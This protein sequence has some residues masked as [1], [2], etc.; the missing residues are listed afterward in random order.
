MIDP[1]QLAS[2][3][4]GNAISLALPGL[5]WA[6][7]FLL[8][9]ERGPFAASVG[10][11][12]RAFWLLLPG[13][14][15]CTFGNLPLVPVTNDVLGISL[16]G[17]LFPILVGLLAFRQYAP[18]AARSVPWFVGGFAAMGTAALLVAIFVHPVWLED[19]GVTV[20][21]A[22]VPLVVWS[23]AA[24]DRAVASRVGV[25]LGLT[26]GV[27]LLT[28]LFAS[29]VPGVG[30]TEAFPEYLLPP[31]GAAV[32]ALFVVPRVAPHAEGLALPAAYV[33]GTFGVL[34]GADILRQPPLYPSSSPGLYV[35]G[36]AGIFDLVYLSGLIALGMAFV[37]HW[38]LDRG[39]TPVG[40]YT[41]SA[42][43]PIGRLARSFRMG[44]RGDLS[45]SLRSASLAGREAAAESR[46][47]MQLPEAPPDRPW[48]GLPV[49]G[50]V[51]ADQANLDAVAAEGTSSGKESYRGWLMA[52]WLVQ[53]SLHLN[54]R[55]FA[56]AFDRAIA[57]CLDLLLLTAPA[58]A[59]WAY[60]ARTLPGGYV[61]VA[62]SV[63][64]NVAVYGYI[65]LAFL[66]FV[67]AERW[68]GTTVGKRLMD[69]EVRERSMS[70]PAL[71]PLLVRNA[72]KVPTLSILGVG[73][74]LAVEFLFIVSGP[75]DVSFGGVIL[76]LGAV[77]AAFL[78]VF[79]LV[80]V[81]LLGVIGFLAIAA[82]A[83]R[84]RCGDLLAGTWVV[85]RLT[86]V[87]TSRPVPVPT[88]APSAPPAAPGSSG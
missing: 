63:A 28:F 53:V 55:R 71:L 70:S 58:I 45:G 73:L 19:V 10:L 46:R 50:W 47:L 34:A 77:T 72:F 87:P 60:L 66:Y 2:D 30:I 75:G 85:R 68:F 16:G 48:Q 12:R 13:A 22:V 42:P 24:T 80:G 7:L 35:I 54:A 38:A 11:G 83:E 81:V 64:F 4:A 32:V 56:S 59:V 9:F 31:L 5:L 61:G 26:S 84:Q 44:L 8:A 20:V 23:L 27:T 69:L 79:V 25:L 3:I 14:I 76:S 1:L 74:G 49:P 88:P 78:A 39:W 17:A 51:V 40:G 15:A 43:T 29:A 33:S 21:L 37:G 65:A 6:A 86:P 41:E 18:P 52:R 82:T 36:G 67:L 62:S 57:F